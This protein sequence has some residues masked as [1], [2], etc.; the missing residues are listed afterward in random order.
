MGSDCAFN[1]VTGMRGVGKTFAM[2]MQAVKRYIK[3]GHSWVYLRYND[4]MIQNI[5]KSPNPFLGDLE[6]EEVF[7]DYVFKNEGVRLYIAERAKNP[8]WECFG[9]M[10]PITS[11]DSYKG[12]TA[13]KVW[14]M[15]LDEF[16]KEREKRYVPYPPNV[17]HSFYNL[18]DTFDR[19]ENRV[20]FV[21]LANEADLVN[22]F[23]R[24]WG[25]TPIPKGTHRIFR[26]NKYKCLYESAWNAEYEKWSRNSILGKMTAGTSYDDYAV[27][28][29]FANSGDMFISP[30]PKGSH[31]Q[32]RIHWQGVDFG[33]WSSLNFGSLYV[34][35]KPPRNCDCIVLTRADMRPDY[36]MIDRSHPYLKS[37]VKC[38]GYGQLLFDKPQT[39]ELFL[40][41]LTLCGLK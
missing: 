16:I 29:N 40:D 22:P 34:N 37:L 2:K 8:K 31:C 24:E 20:K 23:F 18:F 38:Y 26:V 25:I 17:V 33:V 13:P 35:Q 10:A 6:T 15:V 3:D 14:L 28:S 9:S 30:I 5:L 12:T 32:M 19:R 27:G 39:R 4:V 41:M 21:G 11:F 36:M 7:P 1:L